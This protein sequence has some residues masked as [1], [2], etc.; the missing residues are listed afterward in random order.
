MCSYN[1]VNGVPSCASAFLLQTVL[2]DSWNFSGYVTSDSGAIA[3]IYSQHHYLNSTA[4]EGVAYAI[5]AG[6]DIDSSLANGYFNS[7]SPYIAYAPAA[8]AAGLV[9]DSDIDA[10]V[11]RTLRI[12][13]ELGLFDPIEKQPYWHYD[14]AT[15]VDT[16][17][18]QALNKLASREALVLLKNEGARLPLDKR[19][20]LALIGPHVNAQYALVGNYLGQICAEG[21]G[22][23]SC[24]LTPAEAIRQ[25]VG[26]AG[27]VTVAEGC[28]VSTNST[29]GFAEALAAAEVADVI[30]LMMGLDTTVVEREGPPRGLER[31]PVDTQWRTIADCTGLSCARV[32]AMT[33][34]RSAYRARS[35]SCSRQSSQSPSSATGG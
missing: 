27:N 10:L 11:R 12:R 18:S 5:K 8:L 30:V 7:G 14:A 25:A 13:F 29:A 20:S 19:H 1:S 3:D 16:A 2:R 28:D 35:S 15:V 34:R 22:V 23:Y 6:C 21:F 32:Q 31:I 9:T 33:V 26:S 17:Q 4:A 24:I